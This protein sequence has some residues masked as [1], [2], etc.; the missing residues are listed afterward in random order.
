MND[1]DWVKIQ[2]EYKTD[3]KHWNQEEIDE[4]LW[5]MGYTRQDLEDGTLR[6]GVRRILVQYRI[7]K[8]VYESVN[9]VPF[10]IDEITKPNGERYRIER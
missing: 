2:L 1:F 5:I 7:L 8:D 4:A 6:V 3:R 10:S 9:G